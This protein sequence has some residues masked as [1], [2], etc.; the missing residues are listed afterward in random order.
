MNPFVAQEV[1]QEMVKEASPL[2]W[3]LRMAGKALGKTVGGTSKAVG[4]ATWRTGQA[5]VRNPGRTAKVGLGG[6]GIGWPLHSAATRSPRNPI[7]DKYLGH[8]PD[9]PKMP[10]MGR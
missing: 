7:R 5:I 8:R 9:P 3:G 6:L 4:K 1:M 10:T 2:G